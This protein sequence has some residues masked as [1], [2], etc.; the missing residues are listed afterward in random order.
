LPTL[1]RA[2]TRIVWRPARKRSALIRTKNRL[3]VVRLI[4]LPSRKT[5]ILLIPDASRAL[6][7]QS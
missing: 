4:G 3:R 7:R 6:I 1:S 2:T 5:L